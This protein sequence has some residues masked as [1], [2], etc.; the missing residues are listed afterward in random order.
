MVEGAVAGVDWAKDF[1][2][3]LIA[4][5]DGE[6]LWAATVTHDEAGLTKLCSALRSFKVQRVAVERPDGLLVDRLLDAGMIVLAI[7]PNKVQAA[8]D[9]FRPA[10]GKSDRFDAFVL[11]ELARTDSHRFAA[12]GV[13]CSV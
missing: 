2:E 10:G 9:P 8:R 11:C 1:H 12:E 3:V 13:R 4:D 5:A 6:R 7:H